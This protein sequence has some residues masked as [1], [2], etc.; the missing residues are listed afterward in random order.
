MK[1][2]LLRFIGN[3]NDSIAPIVCVA[4]SVLLLASGAAIDY[5]RALHEDAEVQ[6]ALDAAILASAH[7]ST[8]REMRSILRKHFYSRKP[9]ARVSRIKFSAGPNGKTIT[10]T[11]NSEA[12][13]TIMA[14]TGKKTT[15]VHA[16]SQVVIPMKVSEVKF[17]AVKAHGWYSKKIKLMVRPVGSAED[18]QVITGLYTY[19]RRGRSSFTVAPNQWV[20][21][22]NYQHV[23]LQMEIDPNSRGWGRTWRTIFRSDDPKYSSRFFINGKQVP[24]NTKI[25]LLNLVPCGKKVNLA[26]EDGGGHAPDIYFDMETKCGGFDKTT[27]RLTR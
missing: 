15:K 24:R 26:W 18:I 10:A 27:L 16:L 12:A 11:A 22:G 14:I 3:R 19:S 2:K 8:N 23:Y 13:T 6:D 25:D 21:L 4:T 5:S 1:E 7:G 20:G 17:R 9:N